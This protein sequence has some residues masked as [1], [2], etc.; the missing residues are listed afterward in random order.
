MCMQGR[1]VQLLPRV[2]HAHLLA[3]EVQPPHCPADGRDVRRSTN[4][5]AELAVDL[6][7]HALVVEQSHE[8]EQLHVRFESH[9]HV[10]GTREPPSN[11]R[12]NIAGLAKAAHDSLHGAR[13]HQEMGGYLVVRLGVHQPLPHHAPCQ[14]I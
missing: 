14:V 13:V 4:E 12:C 11:I 6:L 10:A 1:E 7:Q 5:R 8:L 3:R 9:D 2:L